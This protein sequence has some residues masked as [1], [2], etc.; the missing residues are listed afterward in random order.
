MEKPLDIKQAAEHLGVTVQT[1]YGKVH[2][3]DVPFHKPSGKLYF[4]ASELDAWIKGK[5][6]TE[7][8]K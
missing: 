4:Y 6:K 3:K 1:M 7:A 2:R 5:T 8:N